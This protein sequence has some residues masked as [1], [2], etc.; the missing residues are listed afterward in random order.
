MTA[1]AHLKAGRPDAAKPLLTAI[2]LDEAN[3]PTLR[4]RAAQ[5]ALSLGVDARTLKLEPTTISTP[6]PAATPAPPAP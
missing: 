4:G 3:P 1:L 6:A 5:L 2:V